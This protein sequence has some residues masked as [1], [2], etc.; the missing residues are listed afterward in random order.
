MADNDKTRLGFTEDDSNK[1]K[2]ALKGFADYTKAVFADIGQSFQKMVDPKNIMSVMDD[3]E[4]SAV[5]IAKQFGQGRENVVTLQAAFGD[6]L[7]KVT[8][9]GGSLTDI[10]R[11]QKGIVETTGR[12][13]ILTG[14]QFEQIYAAQEATG[15][16]AE[17]MMKSFKDVGMSASFINSEMQKVVDVA[18]QQGV[19]A[20][21][22]SSKVVQNM[23]ALNKFNFEGGVQGLAK[24]AAQATQLR[25]DMSTTLN[26]ADRLFD[27]ENAIEMA[28]SMQRL[29][30]T[31]S[32]LLDPLRLMDMA[33]N[34]PAELQNQLAEMS[35]KFVQMGKDGNFEIMPNAK[36][37]LREIE[38]ALNLP[39]G[40]LSNMALA[41][42]EL[43][44]KLSKIRFP[45]SI[46]NE[47]TQKMIANMAE[48]DKSTGEY[49][50]QFTNKETGQVE[51]KSIA[52][53]TEED[54]KAI[55]EASAPKSME[56]LAKEQLT[57]S[58]RIEKILEAIAKKAGAGLAG[59]RV[60]EKTKEA[61][62]GAYQAIGKGVEA[63][64]DVK[65]QREFYQKTGQEA[66]T[67]LKEGDIF[68][69]LKDAAVST[70]TWLESSLN[71]SIEGLST[72][73]TEL[74]K[75]D[76]EIIDAI[77]GVLKSAKNVI[78]KNEK[79]DLGFQ[80]IGMKGAPNLEQEK[81]AL[82]KKEPDKTTSNIQQSVK[83]DPMSL[84]I[85][86]KALGISSED[87][88]KAFDDTDVKQRMV[89]ALLE[90]LNLGSDPQKLR[91]KL[92]KLEKM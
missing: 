25:I 83:V 19:S 37:E 55:G 9:M 61:T 43:E 29:G 39:A 6:A 44:N 49:I 84:T 80:K 46:A 4:S 32:A 3:M 16:Q 5:K 7:T 11:I 35:K 14:E 34:D 52:S 92:D 47:D 45:D 50:V 66:L 65:S 81:L 74:A 10:E 2:S 63:G 73:F 12:N 72:S 79:I 76:N 26:M 41:G 18:R 59:T 71:K 21:E 30:V 58:V 77:T 20:Q 15:Q 85:D 87:V 23:S 64:F 82:E 86:I 42:A 70:V 54:V 69:G 8:E 27:P 56:D 67:N 68:G 88:K 51:K 48:L 40:Q 36:R 31:Q 38:R 33:Q 78:E 24:M 91:E 28:A 90:G 62:V 53:L 17:T 1:S 60:A 13:V 75:K 89:T 57:T 22:V